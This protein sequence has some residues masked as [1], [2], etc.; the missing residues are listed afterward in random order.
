[1]NLGRV[2]TDLTPP[3][4]A[5]VQ[6]AT[7]REQAREHRY[8]YQTSEVTWAR[9]RYSEDRRVL[10]DDS[11]KKRRKDLNTIRE[12]RIHEEQKRYRLVT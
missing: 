1:M 10:Q 5:E 11:P 8:M 7:R 4:E 3:A 12:Y 2:M 6:A 9:A